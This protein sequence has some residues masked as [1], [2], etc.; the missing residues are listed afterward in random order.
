MY[1]LPSSD[2]EHP[3][4]YHSASTY[5]RLKRP[6]KIIC[7]GKISQNQM[8]KSSSS[9]SSDPSSKKK[10]KTTTSPCPHCEQSTK[11]PAYVFLSRSNDYVRISRSRHPPKAVEEYKGTKGFVKAKGFPRT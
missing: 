6:V 1:V 3:P 7:C 11:H 9:S 8:G 4:S 2:W 10:Q 5:G